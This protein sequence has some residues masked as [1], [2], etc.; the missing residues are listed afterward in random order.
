MEER[1]GKEVGQKGVEWKRGAL[2][3]WEGAATVSLQVG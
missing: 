2:K 3:V 1:Q